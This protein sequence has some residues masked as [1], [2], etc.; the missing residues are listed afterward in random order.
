MK[1]QALRRTS[2]NKQQNNDHGR[3][4][5]TLGM[6]KML[7]ALLRRRSHTLNGIDNLL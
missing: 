1:L 6:T 7:Q 5:A 2:E 4:L 3:F